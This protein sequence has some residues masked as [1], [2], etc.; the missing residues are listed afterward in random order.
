M[1]VDDQLIDRIYEAAII[2]ENWP[3][4]LEE[5]SA[6]AGCYGGTLFAM[7]AQQEVRHVST[8]QYRDVMQI[9]L[10]DGWTKQNIRATRLE[11]LKYPGFVTDCDVISVEEMDAHPFY[12]ELLRPNGGGWAI[13]TIIPVPSGDLLVFNL[14][15]RY[16]RGPIEKE[17]C[18][19]LDPLRPHLAR[20]GLMASRLRMERAR[21]MVETLKQIGLPAAV[22]RENGQA[23]A[24]N[25]LF[26]LLSNQISIGAF[27]EI[28]IKN[29]S[30]DAL[31]KKSL[32]RLKETRDGSELKSIP[33]PAT[34]DHPALV[35]HLIPIKGGA[36][37]IFSRAFSILLI[38]PLHAP[39][40]PTE[41]VLNGLFDLS[42]AEVKVA[43]G[44]ISG[45]TIEGV[46]AELHL[47]RE[48][49]RTQLK[50][51]FAKTGTS[52]QAEL[53]GLLATRTFPGKLSP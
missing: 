27:D 1:A 18:G 24:I 39:T 36:H 9:F 26:Q 17:L 31:M 13:G 38:T 15:R 44:I 28:T 7:D 21:A 3:S 10:R 16:G 47:S 51:V 4:I 25:D 2:P 41:D 45:K 50:S 14:E 8:D 11:K 53:V 23:L 20:A 37:D 19:R 48:T 5:I 40:A 46:A 12:T 42:P 32:V 52:R 49:I 33:I 22:L 34:P 29:P 6:I 43:Q 35:A 30:S